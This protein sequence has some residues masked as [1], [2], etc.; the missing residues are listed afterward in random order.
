MVELVTQAIELIAIVALVVLL[1]MGYYAI[2]VLGRL[3]GGLLQEGW[4]WIASAAIMVLMAQAILVANYV[5]GL[6]AEQTQY[7][8]LY[9]YFIKLIAGALFLIGFRAQYKIW[10]LKKTEEEEQ[11]AKS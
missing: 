7:T 3:K 10:R 5:F 11:V 8:S 1:L 9:A 4:K 2:K 6:S